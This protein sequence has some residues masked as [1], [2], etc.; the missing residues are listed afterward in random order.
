MVPNVFGMGLTSDGGLF[1]TKPYICGSN[2][3]RKMSDHGSGQWCET[4]DGLFWRFVDKHADRLR[5]NP[6]LAL[7]V[8]Q[9]DR[10]EAKR[11]KRLFDAAD[12]FIGTHTQ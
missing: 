1:T 4:V 8:T 5:K 10:I 7:M 2:Y 9:S 6:R 11:R 12:T 3:M